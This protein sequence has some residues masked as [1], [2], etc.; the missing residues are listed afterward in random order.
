KIETFFTRPGDLPVLLGDEHRLPL[1]D[2]DLGW[3]DLNLE[4]HR[5]LL[6]AALATVA[7]PRSCRQNLSHA[8]YLGATAVECKHL[9]TIT[10]CPSNR[11]RFRDEPILKANARQSAL[12]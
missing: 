2:G 12:S 4:R 7:Q 5:V 10:G 3:T 9:I 6:I 11:C 8:S 1:M